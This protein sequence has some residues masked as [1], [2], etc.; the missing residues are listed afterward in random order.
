MGGRQIEHSYSKVGQS[1]GSGVQSLCVH[2]CKRAIRLFLLPC[3]KMFA[4]HHFF[5]FPVQ[6]SVG[7]F[8]FVCM[9][10]CVCVCVYLCY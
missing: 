3:Y 9:S 2:V 6:G 10:V 4:F 8:I 7:G 5:F 1:V